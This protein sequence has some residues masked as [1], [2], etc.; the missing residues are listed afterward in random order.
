MPM[1]RALQKCGMDNSFKDTSLACKMNYAPYM[2][3]S[4]MISYR[5]ELISDA[6]QVRG[7]ILQAFFNNAI[8]LI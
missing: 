8:V 3:F 5:F 1:S 2:S 4:I 7:L 6:P